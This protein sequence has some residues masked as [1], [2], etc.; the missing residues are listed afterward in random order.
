MAVQSAVY[1]DPGLRWADEDAILAAEEDR[2]AV[3][4]AEEILTISDD[5]IVSWSAAILDDDAL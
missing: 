5:G 3:V 1:T 4:A 2:M